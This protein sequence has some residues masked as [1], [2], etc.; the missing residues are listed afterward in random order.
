MEISAIIRAREII[1][2]LTPLN[3]DCGTLCDKACCRPDADGKGGVSLFPG[4][5]E[6][7]QNADWHEIIDVEFA[8]LLVCR[9]ICPRDA[10]PLGCRIFPLTPIRRENRLALRIDARAREMCPLAR[11]GVKGVRRDFALAVLAA[12]REIDKTAE[13]RRFID[14]WIDIESK[15]HGFRL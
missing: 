2:D 3:Q 8:P 15:F 6:L 1:G 5:A 11:S 4:E 12:L 10:R 7:Y 13:G 14:K 9:G